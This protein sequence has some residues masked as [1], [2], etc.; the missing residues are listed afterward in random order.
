ML[1][2]KIALL[3]SIL[4]TLL[5]SCNSIEPPPDNVTISLSLADAGSIEAWIKLT[6]T[7]LQFPATVTLNKNNA[8]G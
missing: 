8:V 4:I 3:P 2:I 1:K 5:Q 6:T 7:N